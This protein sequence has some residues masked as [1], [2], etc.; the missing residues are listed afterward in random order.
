MPVTKE[1]FFA[2]VETEINNAQSRF[3]PLNSLHEAYAVLL[4]EVDEVF[5]QMKLKESKRDHD[6]LIKELVQVASC[7]LR[8]VLDVVNDP[9]KVPP[10]KPSIEVALNDVNN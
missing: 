6:L 4:E 3:P 5:E 8:T 2:M 7:A 1:Q 9:N 10:P